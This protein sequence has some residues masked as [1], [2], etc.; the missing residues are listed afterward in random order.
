MNSLDLCLFFSADRIIF[1]CLLFRVPK[2]SFPEPLSYHVDKRLED[3]C[4]T[5]LFLGRRM[6][7]RCL[8]Y[9]AFIRWL[10]TSCTSS[11]VP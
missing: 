7:G 4:K 10:F 3:M 6:Y 8:S 9:A 11:Q 5:A 2:V 1:V